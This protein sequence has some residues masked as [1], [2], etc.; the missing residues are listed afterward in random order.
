MAGYVASCSRAN[1][2]RFLTMYVT[3]VHKELK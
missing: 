2:Q 1:V 3:H